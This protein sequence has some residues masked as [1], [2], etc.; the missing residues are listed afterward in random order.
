MSDQS[1]LAAPSGLCDKSDMASAAEKPS[2]HD[3]LMA[4][5]PADLT[6]NNWA[7]R[8]GVSRNVWRDMKKHDNPTAETLQK[9]LDVVG[10][11]YVQ[12][13]ASREPVR[14]EVAGAGLATAADVRRAYHGEEPLRALPLVGT[15]IGGE[16][17]DL[18]EDI[19]LVE[20]H[21]GEVLDYL[22]RPASLALDPD[23]YAVRML[24]DSMAPKFEPGETLAVSPRQQVAINDYVLVQLRGGEGDDERIKTVLIKRLRRRG[25]SFIEFEQFN[26]A[27]TFRIDAK[28]V[29]VMHHVKGALF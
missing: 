13:I 26:P 17:G 25:G 21:L 8:A 14:S 16:H 12:F 2:V 6:L 18:D 15:A 19:D 9:L 22:A 5:K 24:T 1:E 4:L 23:A 28:R 10:I 3:A 20:L 27:R 7:V 11:S 29:A